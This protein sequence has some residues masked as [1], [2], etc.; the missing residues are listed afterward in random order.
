M[1][2]SI[3]VCCLLA[4]T[5]TA[6][7]VQKSYAQSTTTTVTTADFTT[8]VNL[9]DSQ[10]GSGD[11]TTARETWNL[12]HQ[13][14]LSVLAKTKVSINSSTLGSAERTSYIALIDNQRIIYAAIW[15]MKPD[16]A[17]NRSAIH[18][19]LLEFAATIY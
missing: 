2:R 13:M 19:K 5:C 15:Q 11:L 16:L 6:T 7:F 10:I 3:L 1:T 18:A 14:M 12:I 9:M 17:T 8:K 4:F